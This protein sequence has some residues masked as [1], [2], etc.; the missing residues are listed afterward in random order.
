MANNYCAKCGEKTI[1]GALFCHNCG[2]KFITVP[3]SDM[4]NGAVGT[5]PVVNGNINDVFSGQETNINVTE[6]GRDTSNDYAGNFFEKHKRLIIGIATIL[7]AL[8]VKL[9]IVRIPPNAN[10]GVVASGILGA[11]TGTALLAVVAAIGYNMVLCLLGK[12]SRVYKWELFC[13][14]VVMHMFYVPNK[15]STVY[16]YLMIGGYIMYV[17][18]LVLYF[19]NKRKTE[20]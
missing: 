1:P 19:W 11:A 9:S 14:S 4:G 2:Y 8:V 13:A 17:V 6:S 12:V 18:G 5:E 3:L 16:Y 10:V 20:V 7:V 15:H